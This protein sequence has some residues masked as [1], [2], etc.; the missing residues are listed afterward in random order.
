MPDK[1]IDLVVTD[2]PFFDNVHYSQLADF[3]YY[4][5]NQILD[6]SPVN[7]TRCESEVQDTDPER[8][9]AKLT[10]VSPD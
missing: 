3:F 1:S 9:K 4:W 6:L 8:F 2:P 7:T 10:S 5:L